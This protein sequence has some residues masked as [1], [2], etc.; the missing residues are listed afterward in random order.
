MNQLTSEATSPPPS[1]T[2]APAT[3]YTV[4]NGWAWAHLFVRHG[5]RQETDGR[6]TS[7]AHVSVVSDYGSFGFC[8]THMGP[9]TWHEFL[10]GLSFGYA[11][12]KFM[13]AGFRVPMPPHDAANK[14]RRLVL[15]ARR[16][17]ISAEAARTLFDAVEAAETADDEDGSFLRAW[18]RHS[19]GAMYRHELY[20][21]DWTQPSPQA[22]GFWAEI[23]PHFIAAI[24]PTAEA[25]P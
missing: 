22:I 19:G 25:A 13:G 6:A 5:V 24:Q 8:W 17:G 20:D 18:D 2:V 23:W 4:R 10:A 3:C 14:A 7:W 16:N 15:E 9:R 1:V 11:M 21:A 12:Q